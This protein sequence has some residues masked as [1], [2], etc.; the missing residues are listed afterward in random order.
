MWKVQEPKLGILEKQMIEYEHLLP[1]YDKLEQLIY[2]G[3]MRKEQLTK[4]NLEKEKFEK[5]EKENKIR[6]TALSEEMENLVIDDEVLI[7]LEKKV[8]FIKQ[9]EQEIEKIFE[10]FEQ[11]HQLAN[12]EQRITK[13][14]QEENTKYLKEQQTC[15][16]REQLFFAAQAGILAKDLEESVQHLDE[17]E[18]IEV[19]AYDID[20]LCEMI[21]AGKIQDAKTVSGLLAYKNTL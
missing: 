15:M 2:D 8:T 10:K 19:E 11:W 16:E 1:E 9:K 20:E 6:E 13:Q 17:G 12:E 4:L 5:E 14:L 3:R 21:Y 7:E 18:T